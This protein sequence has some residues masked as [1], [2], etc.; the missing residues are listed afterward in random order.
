[1]STALYNAMSAAIAQSKQLDV[2]AQNVAN[3]STPGFRA[4]RMT[5]E[6]VLGNTTPQV[7]VGPTLPDSSRGEMQATG[8]PLDLALP[9]EGYF[10][11]STPN[12]DR[13]TRAGAFAIDA[14][15]YV[16]DP[17]GN[18]LQ[19][20]GGRAL[21]IDPN[22]PNVSVGED[23]TVKAGDEVVGQVRV[24]FIARGDLV[25]EGTVFAA[26][27]EATVQEIEGAQVQSGVLESSNFDVVRGLA[28]LV[29][30]SRN[31]EAAVRTMQTMS[32]QQKRT[33]RGFGA[34]S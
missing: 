26:S 30:A 2:T 28:D 17:R 34:G 14:E 9:G 3:A 21:Q 32:E 27:E 12:G 29:R 23:G 22:A 15:G 31:Y 24:A 7:R 25:N 8:R 11:L 5:F 10:A 19:D 20:K 1:M 4:Q 16:V 13:F 6:E 33:A 18:M